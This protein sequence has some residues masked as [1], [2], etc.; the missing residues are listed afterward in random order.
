MIKLKDIQKHICKLLYSKYKDYDIITEEQVADVEN[1]TFFIDVRPVTTSN[2]M[3]YKYK[4]V[5]VDIYYV[6]KEDIH[7]N[8]LDIVDNLQ[9]IFEVQELKVNG[10]HL[11]IENLSF[12][13]PSFLICSFTIKYFD[14]NTNVLPEDNNSD[15][16]ETLHN[17]DNN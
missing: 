5:N 13:E 17:R 4:T 16:M 15:K 12:S 6:D 3:R 14:K 8:N 7:Q 1:P 9:E 2:Y 10:T 11:V